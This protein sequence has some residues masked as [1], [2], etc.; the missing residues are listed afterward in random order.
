MCQASSFSFH[1]SHGVIPREALGEGVEHSDVQVDP[2]SKVAN[3][4]GLPVEPLPRPF[5]SFS[6]G[7]MCRLHDRV[8]AGNSLAVVENGVATCGNVDKALPLDLGD[9]VM[10]GDKGIDILNDGGEIPEPWAEV[11]FCCAAKYGAP[12]FCVMDSL[13]TTL[14]CRRVGKRVSL[15]VGDVAGLVGSASEIAAN[16]MGELDNGDKVANAESKTH[17]GTSRTPSC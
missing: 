2:G 10:I 5:R 3:F 16:F 9:V 12:C 7:A 1:Q 14:A 13:A 17:R 15:L 8:L 6:Y 4:V 11:S